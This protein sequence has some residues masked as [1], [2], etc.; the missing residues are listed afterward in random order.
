MCYYVFVWSGLGIQGEVLNQL[1]QA[2]NLKEKTYELTVAPLYEGGVFP[3]NQQAQ[4]SMDPAS[5]DTEVRG[6]QM[7]SVLTGRAPAA[8]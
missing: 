5:P 8:E 3:G 1:S 6:M 4:W 2:F 7:R